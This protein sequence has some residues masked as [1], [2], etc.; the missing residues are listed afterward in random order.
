MVHMTGQHPPDDGTFRDEPET[1]DLADRRSEYDLQHAL[2][3]D[4]F[5]AGEFDTNA[6]WMQLSDR[7]HAVSHNT[8]E[9]RIAPYIAPRIANRG[10]WAHRGGWSASM[11]AMVTSAA[12]LVVGFGVWRSSSMHATSGEMRTYTT[13]T[14]QRT[15][16]H[17]GDGSRV[18]LAPQSRLRVTHPFGKDSRRVDLIG[19]AFF[20][21]PDA[22]STPFIVR[23][24]SI[25]TRVLGTRFDVRRYPHDAVTQV[26]VETG[27]V[28]T[29]GRHA[30]VVLTAGR[31]ARI[32][33]SIVDTSNTSRTE[34]ATS[35]VDGRL[36]F[37][38]ASVP[39]MLATMGRWYGYTFK[40]ADS[41]LA[42]ARVRAE[43][44]TNT[45]EEA[46]LILKRVLNVTLT[47]D[48][49]VITLH[50]RRDGGRASVRRDVRDSLLKPMEAGK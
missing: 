49:P 31:M 35:W 34:S 14:G 18:V 12:A 6:G 16:I 11:L 47:Y 24:E 32:T 8:P 43:F 4:P 29:A 19:E 21:V 44:Q 7:M 41:T 22:A 48:G 38:G 45:P 42:R 23:T 10:G 26:S 25:D 17:L 5:G 46:L 15:T 13:T 30:R 20:D 39:E 2:R 40:L 28:S 9:Q 50:P 3:G 33:D 27:K 37:D 36:V 1:T